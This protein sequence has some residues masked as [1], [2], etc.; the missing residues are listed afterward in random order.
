MKKLQELNCQVFKLFWKIGNQTFYIIIKV[1]SD[2]LSLAEHL[3][4][5]MPDAAIMRKLTQSPY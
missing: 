4:I 5:V 1:F 3:L 2:T